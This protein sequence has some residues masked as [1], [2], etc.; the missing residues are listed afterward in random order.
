MPRSHSRRIWLRWSGL[1]SWEAGWEVLQLSVDWEPWPTLSLSL[2]RMWSGVM[3]PRLQLASNRRVF[4]TS[5]CR[6]PFSYFAPPKMLGCLPAD[7]DF[8]D[9]CIPL[10][11]FK[12]KYSS[13]N[14][15]KPA[16]LV[17]FCH[18]LM[19]RQRSGKIWR[20]FFLRQLFLA[21]VTVYSWEFAL[22]PVTVK[23]V[24]WFFLSSLW[25]LI[26]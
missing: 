4:S 5:G 3:C 22:L 23:R 25:F 16:I 9:G 21:V 24:A 2:Y 18:Y 13:W 15:L 19:S 17:L 20:S 26:M 7:A 1:D 11:I 6:S 12:I 10:G 8:C 14:V